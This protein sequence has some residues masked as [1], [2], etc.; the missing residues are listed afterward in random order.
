MDNHWVLRRELVRIFKLESTN[1]FLYLLAT[2]YDIPD[3]LNFKTNSTPHVYNIT[4]K[5]SD[6]N[7]TIYRS[8]QYE[9]QNVINFTITT[10]PANTFVIF[11]N[12]S[13][14]IK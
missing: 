4:L 2:S 12:G 11:D 9:T 5:A 13:I 10:I 6:Q 3:Q 1:L 14:K 7:S 8:H